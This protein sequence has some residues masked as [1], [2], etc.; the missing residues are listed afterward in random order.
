MSLSAH[1]T[2]ATILG[3]PTSSLIM[4]SIVFSLSLPSSLYVDSSVNR[5]HSPGPPP[6]LGRAFG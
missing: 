2:S 1:R 3:R 6:D 4:I 5:S